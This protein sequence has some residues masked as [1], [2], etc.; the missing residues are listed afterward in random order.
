MKEPI[1]FLAALIIVITGFVLL[2]TNFNTP[3]ENLNDVITSGP[4]DEC[5]DNTMETWFIE[6]NESQERGAD[7]SEADNAAAKTAL[8]NFDDCQQ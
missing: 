5:F 1:I 2:F 8:A 3:P 7:M 4:I 6:F